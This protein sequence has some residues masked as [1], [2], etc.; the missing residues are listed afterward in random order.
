VLLLLIC[1]VHL[2]DLLSLPDID[3]GWEL[4]LVVSISMLFLVVPFQ[5]RLALEELWAMMALH[6]SVT[7]LTLVTA[8]LRNSKKVVIC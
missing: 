4:S 5:I 6:C 7:W 2:G 8:V 3:L 1:E